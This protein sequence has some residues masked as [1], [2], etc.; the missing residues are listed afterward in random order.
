MQA[1]ENGEEGVGSFQVVSAI[2]NKSENSGFSRTLLTSGR[3]PLM[4][5]SKAVVAALLD[6]KGA[7]LLWDSLSG[8]TSDVSVAIHAYYEGAV[9]AYNAKVTAK[10]D[11]VYTHFSRISNQ[12]QDYT[13][14]QLRKVVDDLQRTGDLQ[15]DVLDRSA[16]LGIKADDMDGILELVTYK[17]IELMF[18]HKSGWAADPEREAAVEANQIPGRQER[19]FLS[20]VFRGAQRHEVLHRRSIRSEGSEGHPP[21]LLHAHARQE[22]HHQGP[23]RHRRQHRRPLRRAEERPALLPHRR[24]ERPGLRVPAGALPGG[25]RVRRLVPGQPQLRVGERAQVVRGSAGVHQG[26]HVHARGD[27]SGHDGEGRRLP[28]PRRARTGLGRIRIP[29]PLEPARRRHAERAF[30]RQMG[31]GQG[32]R[33]RA[34]AAVRESASSR[35][36]AIARSSPPRASPPPSSTS[37]PRSAARTAFSARPSCA[38]QTPRRRPAS[39]YFAIAIRR[40][41]CA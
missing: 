20:S 40:W 7:T 16:G 37:C 21:Q 3:A 4:P 23:R 27:Q 36:T 31:E 2:L 41:W 11:T 17:L 28:A 14:R 15:I 32:S 18:D 29:T 9:K 10:V 12:Q 25:R 6:E 24:H 8:P 22:H 35:S 30:R 39:R 26:A 13:R 5:G 19:G 1:L 38:R 33:H 34:D